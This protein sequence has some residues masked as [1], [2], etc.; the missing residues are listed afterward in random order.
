[1][2]L[3]VATILIQSSIADEAFPGE[4]VDG[5][6]TAGF[7]V[8]KA[9]AMLQRKVPRQQ[10][11]GEESRL[12]SL[13]A[14]RPT[15]E[16]ADACVLPHFCNH[17]DDDVW[18]SLC[19]HWREAN[20]AGAITHGKDTCCS[21]IPPVCRSDGE[22]CSTSSDCLKPSCKQKDWYLSEVYQPAAI[23]WDLACFRQCAFQMAQTP[24]GSFD[25]NYNLSAESLQARKD[26]V[27]DHQHDLDTT[28]FVLVEELSAVGSSSIV[29]GEVPSALDQVG[30]LLTSR[31][32]SDGRTS[33]RQFDKALII[34]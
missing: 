17:P 8:T 14:N 26:F 9:R 27:K 15:S 28:A 1:M 31:R 19:S 18:L 33:R 4:A 21:S 7:C 32:Q 6:C 5:M 25:A 23:A 29:A 22:T 11:S 10:T 16:D 30:S 20:E 24:C 34:K 3:I 13:E 2:Y 12:G